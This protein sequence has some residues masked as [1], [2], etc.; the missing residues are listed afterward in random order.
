MRNV[1]LPS[2][3]FGTC[4]R[5][6]LPAA[7]FVSS[8][9]L[10]ML[11]HQRPCPLEPHFSRISFS[12]ADPS[13]SG[14]PRG[15]GQQWRRADKAAVQLGRARM[16]HALDSYSRSLLP[17]NPG[18]GI[19]G[20]RACASVH[21]DRGDDGG[22]GGKTSGFAGKDDA[23]RRAFGK[24]LCALM[25]SG[26]CPGSFLHSELRA[27]R[28]PIEARESLSILCS[29]PEK[30]FGKQR[31]A[32]VLPGGCRLCGSDLVRDVTDPALSAWLL[33][34]FQAVADQTRSSISQYDVRKSAIQAQH[35]A[36][37]CSSDGIESMASRSK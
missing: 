6:S 35:H 13:R 10:G 23:A 28:M 12:A 5:E 26:E 9:L 2:G 14:K 19:I 34:M 30:L 20:L 7:A 32:P 25:L 15:P 8:A 29:S 22:I 37:T 36:S 1:H 16:D 11:A 24:E 33:R 3:N 21:H 17:V 4:R 31:T 18:M 27:P